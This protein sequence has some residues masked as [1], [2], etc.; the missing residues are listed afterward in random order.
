MEALGL[1]RAQSQV[2]RSRKMGR[3]TDLA[4]GRVLFR[5]CMVP[6][7]E[8]FS[9]W[10]KGKDRA[11]VAGH[12]CDL[13]DG[14]S[15]DFICAMCARV[16]IDGCAKERSYYSIAY[17]IGSHLEDERIV[18]YMRKQELTLWNDLVPKLKYA[19]EDHRRN[20]IRK[21]RR[22]WRKD[23]T[24][25]PA[26]SQ[27]SLSRD[28]KLAIGGFLTVMFSECT[29]VVE[30]QSKGN[31]G[32]RPTK[33]HNVVPTQDLLK[34]LETTDERHELLKPVFLP[35]L[36]KPL[37]WKSDF[38][39]GYIPDLSIRTPFCKSLDRRNAKWAYQRDEMPE[40]FDAVDRIQE[41]AWQVSPVLEVAEKVWAEGLP[42]AGLPRRED[43]PVPERP[44]TDDETALKSY[45]QMARVIHA[46][47]RAQRSKRLQVMK[48]LW[49]GD[50]YRDQS[51]LYFPHNLCFRG[52]AY[53][54]PLFLTPQGSD[55]SKA[56][57]R[58]A[59]PST[60]GPEN[61]RLWKIQGANTWG[62][63]K[64]P[65]DERV[66]WVEDNW[67]MI[68]RVRRDPLQNR[69]WYDADKPWQFLNWCMDD[70]MAP[71]VP[72]CADGTN[73]GLQVIAALTGD[74]ETAFHTNL[75]RS[76]KPQDIYS[77]VAKRATEL[78]ETSDHKWAQPWLAF[79]GGSLPRSAVKRQVMTQP[80][81][82][83]RHSCTDYTFEAFKT[84]PA[85]ERTM[86]PDDQYQR[87]YWLS[88][89]I[90]E[91]ITDCL[92][93]PRAFMDWAS[94]CAKMAAKAQVYLQWQLPTG[95]WVFQRYRR[96][97]Y[98]NVKSEFGWKFTMQHRSREWVDEL[99]PTKAGQATP[100]NVVH[101]I[102]AAA[103]MRTV[104]LAYAAGVR[105]F[106][107]VHDDFGTSAAHAPIL[108]EKTREAYVQILSEVSLEGL[109]RTWQ[110]LCEGKGVTL[111]PPPPRGDFNVE[112]ILDSPY[113]FS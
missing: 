26:V 44:K 67:D 42:V 10:R 109:H 30:I 58:F 66:K 50:Q 81:G 73:N 61:S 72:V 86:W 32:K 56:C 1:S 21:V 35:V 47:N 24:K 60:M 84:H 83:T 78:L 106:A 95:F 80:Y 36:Q 49:V 29:G 55:L 112:E 15:S 93:G 62:M 13:F 102:D 111:P 16:I 100:A 39:G 71:Q 19:G 28:E 98:V 94:D 74:A 18:R 3:M 12:L 103:M 65:F 88:S 52:R 110:A 23:P 59:A 70:P 25:E 91:A 96:H 104:N 48:T 90:W 43:E 53:P 31:R 54:I 5:E 51:A 79:W 37:K 101:S 45:K 33:Y 46:D 75:I 92:K 63:D 41:T 82:S 6:F 14:F 38:V 7:V 20:T 89:I 34:W 40:V 27:T 2:A 4:S 57:L 17:M 64:A 69:D 8:A 77:V 85:Y 107:M 99:N 68:Q 105:D 97:K 22:E 113:F 11:H 87:I 108:A 9:R 76:E